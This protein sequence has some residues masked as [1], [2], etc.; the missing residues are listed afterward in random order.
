MLLMSRNDEAVAAVDDALPTAAGPDA[1]R[2]LVVRARAL[3]GLA[4]FAEA[5]AAAR[6]A[7]E[8][9]P[10]KDR[11]ERSEALYQLGAAEWYRGAHTRALEVLNE[12]L[13]LREATQDRRGIAEVFMALGAVLGDQGRLQRSVE[14]LSLALSLSE[15][16]GDRRAA[17]SARM[18][19]AHALVDIG[20]LTGAQ[21]AAEAARE[22]AERIANPRLVA[23]CEAILAMVVDR[24]GKSRDAAARF[25]RVVAKARKSGDLRLVV[26][27]LAEGVRPHTRI[28]EVAEAQR[29]A[30][31]AADLARK[32]GAGAVEGVALRAL[33]EA[34]A[35]FGDKAAAAAHFEAAAAAFGRMGNDTGM[36]ETYARWGDALLAA[37][38]ASD[39]KARFSE[40][41]HL[42]EASDLKRRA[43]ATRTAIVALAQ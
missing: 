32:I 26:V 14:L 41:L 28:G 15:K 40:A 35:A 36:A 23:W 39:A 30:Q 17:A 24:R 25:E 43:A 3:N 20:D 16:I 13:A 37:K 18:N 7:L 21:R 31:E 29:D 27:A 5:E 6:K 42:F 4:R 38:S 33:G 10:E 8:G 9:F 11:A 12:A 19:M 2:L 1:A 22:A 34:A